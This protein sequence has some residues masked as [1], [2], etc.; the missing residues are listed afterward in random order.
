MNLNIKLNLETIHTHR[1]KKLGAI[2]K[3]RFKSSDISK[4]LSPFWDEASYGLNKVDYYN[5]LNSINKK[6]LLNELAFDRISEAYHI[7][8][9]GIAYGS[10]MTLLSENIDER[11]LYASFTGDEARH[12]KLIEK[13]FNNE[14]HSDISDNSFLVYLSQ[15]IETAPKKSL[16]FMIQVL[17]EG[18][19]LEHYS[20]MAK[21]CKN[22]ELKS[23][24]TSI[25]RDEV[26]H[27]GSGVIL[28]KENGL[29]KL[30]RDYIT[31]S[32]ISFFQMVQ[33]GPIGLVTRL[34]SFT[35]KFSNNN[36]LKILEQLE[37][38]K[39]T[40]K[41]LAILKRLMKKVGATSIIEEMENRGHLQALTID[42]M[43][44]C[45]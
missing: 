5:E 28:F 20:S 23:D 27:H 14:L 10:K 30:E 31:K 33:V 18:W 44:A 11:V 19:G 37:A 29:S 4:S 8:K 26:V 13:Y 42:Q 6:T 22:N 35:S 17:L 9:S 3:K 16:V 24:L 43:A 2:L 15:M 45:F 40:N 7:E 39:Q 41:K 32:L 38:Y 12:F 1:N 25:V 21:D 36:R 34:E